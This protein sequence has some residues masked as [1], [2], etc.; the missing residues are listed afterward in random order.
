MSSNTK[1]IVSML[2]SEHKISL[3][4]DKGEI[5]ELKDNGPHDLTKLSKKLLKSLNGNN[6]V[7]INLNDYLILQQTIVPDGYENKGI[8]VN[9]MIDGQHTQGIFYPSKQ[10]VT[11]QHEGRE[12]TIPDV[13]KLKR[14]AIRANA[15]KSPAVRNFLRRMAPVVESRLHS[16]EDLMSFIEQSELPITNDGMVIAYKKV[17]KG[18]GPGTF[19]D[20]YTG[21]IVQSIGSRVWMNKEEV[22]PSR[23]QSCS[24]GLHVANLDYLKSFSGSH[25]LIVLVDPA[26]FIAV[27]S[28]ET[29][30]CRV[31]V[32]DIIGVMTSEGHKIVSNNKYIKEDQ[33]FKSL[34]QDAVTGRHIQPTEAV[35][36]KDKR[37]ASRTPLQ[38][39]EQPPVELEPVTAR[40][41]KPSGKSLKE[42]KPLL[43]KLQQR[44]IL[45]MVKA[46]TSQNIWDQT[47]SKVIAVFEDLRKETGPKSV[48]AATHDTS[49]RSIG[50]W[51]DKYNYEGYVKFKESNMTIAEQARMYFQ[52]GK[53]DVLSTFRRSK[54]KSLAALGF[55]HR[56]IKQIEKAIKD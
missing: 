25:T 42:D 29:S 27:P 35:E 6:S 8:M 45:N 33:T 55:S 17:N 50:R 51:Q 7:T 22:D 38:D 43:K 26:N 39:A 47:P 53:F 11:V 12:V 31:C 40:T 19:V 49:T 37:I 48:I 23:S 3:Y 4:T 9:Q 2:A 20:C 10:E 28:G 13:E 36:V 32:Y 16:A 14:H 41:K 44:D 30:K 56:E 34:I 15:E 1:N 54:K 5:L 52:Q 24:N 21:N 18:K 46:T